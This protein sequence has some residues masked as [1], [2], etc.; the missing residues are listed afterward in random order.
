[1]VKGLLSRLCNDSK[2]SA[3]YLCDDLA[4]S[5]Y[6]FGVPYSLAVEWISSKVNARDEVVERACQQVYFHSKD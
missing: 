6:D 1:M 4:R 2:K 3:Y 5:Y